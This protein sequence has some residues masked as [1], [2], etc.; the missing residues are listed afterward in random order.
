MKVELFP[1]QKLALANLREK[2]SKA[3][4]GYY[5]TSVP[6][7]ISYTAPTGAGKTIIMAAL[8]E[9]VYYGNEN[10][11]TEFTDTIDSIKSKWPSRDSVPD[12]Y[13]ILSVPY[14]PND[15]TGVNSLYYL[16]RPNDPVYN[17]D[18]NTREVE[19]PPFLSVSGD[20]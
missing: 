3:Q 2:V 15:H 14:D 8:I 1:F 12:F 18:L 13:E 10:Y 17:I 6:Q 4:V 16:L 11:Y 9:S 5:H 19:A 20:H 7:I